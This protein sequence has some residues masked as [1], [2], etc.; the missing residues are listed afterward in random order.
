M[1]PVA[2]LR[3]LGV[4]SAQMLAMAGITDVEQLHELG[5]VAAYRQVKAVCPQA[6]LNLL[7]ALESALTG[8]PWQEVAR[9]QRARLL[10]QLAEPTT[11][12]PATPNALATG[13]LEKGEP[14]RAELERG[15]LDSG[16]PYTTAPEPK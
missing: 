4:K 14:E 11:P 10:A 7:W 3:S 5:P 15:E 13:E 12:V 16:K 6:S 9:W 1:T 2:Q 8:I